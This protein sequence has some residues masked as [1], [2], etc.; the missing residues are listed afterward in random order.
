MTDPIQPCDRCRQD[1]PVR[2]HEGECLCRG[3]MLAVKQEFREK[4]L[5]IGLRTATVGCLLLA[6]CGREPV[7]APVTAWCTATNSA[8]VD[9]LYLANVSPPTIASLT[10]VCR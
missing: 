4:L 2:E 3:C 10:Y 7:T 6:G 9:T 5:A 1:R 8:R